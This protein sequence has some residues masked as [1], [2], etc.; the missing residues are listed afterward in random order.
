MC[1]CSIYCQEKQISILSWNVHRLVHKLCDS[2]FLK[3]VTEYDVIIL[4]ETWLSRNTAYNLNI[5]GYDCYHLYGNKSRAARR[6]RYSGGISVYYKHELSSKISIVEK[7][8]IGIVWLRLHKTLFSFDEDVYLCCIYNV[9]SNSALNDI[10]V[11]FFECVEIGIEKY[12]SK[13]KILISGDF[14]S[15]TATEND[16]V[17]YDEFIDA[18]NE[19][20]A[21]IDL[22]P[23][24]NKDLIVDAYGRK[25]LNLC[26]NTGLLIANGRLNDGEF[27]FQG[28]QGSSTVDYILLNNHDFQYVNE[29]TILEQNEFSD[30][31]PLRL[32]IDRHTELTQPRDNNINTTESIKWDS[33]LSDIFINEITSHQHVL[34]DITH[35]INDN[36]IDESVQ[37]FTAFMQDHAFTVFGERRS[38][39]RFTNQTQ[40]TIK[41][42]W[43]NAECYEARK[44]FNQARNRFL[45]N[46][47]EANRHD[48]LTSKTT[49]NN[50]KRTA[51]YKYKQL[52]G[53]RLTHLAKDKPREF[54]KVIKKQYKKK[55]PLSNTLTV[56]DIYTHFND[57]YGSTPEHNNP[58]PEV[59]GIYDEDLDIEFSDS[60]L[61]DA[62]FSQ[63]NNKSPGLDLLTSEMFKS[64]Y[65]II[66]PLLL[67]L[68]NKVFSSG[69]Y[70]SAWGEG[71]ITPVLKGGSVDDCK[72]YR[73]ITLTNI[74][75]KVYSQLL[76]NR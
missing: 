12:K 45:R 5:D 61:R 62:I 10:N 57:L 6:G 50:I 51:K 30:H 67:K 36:S 33:S 23:R 71:I 32:C 14:N 22:L 43:F 39:N 29:F 60:E 47:T 19:I 35:N 24:T 49:Y 9:P 15:R 38:H 26:K 68:Y 3:Y 66:S 34:T 73:G 18:A 69:N 2:D 74:I 59:H 55:S 72:N 54:W 42:N 21:N 40:R 37:K 27:T 65:N 16:F 28:S 56:D 20:D 48:F 76:L 52:E 58:E 63:N 75:A 17:P 46:R 41:N 64:A 53:E 13:G 4:S 25:L 44:A 1:H 8:Q 11:D 70:P 7:Q 31:S